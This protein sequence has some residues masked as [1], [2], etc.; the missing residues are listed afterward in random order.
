MP[1]QRIASHRR[2]L[3]CKYQAARRNDEGTYTAFDAKRRTL[4]G[5][6]IPAT[7]RARTQLIAAGYLVMEEITGCTEFELIL[8]GLGSREAAA[9]VAALE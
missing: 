2:Y 9:V 6:D 5:T 3:F 8:H 4:S 1:D 7:F